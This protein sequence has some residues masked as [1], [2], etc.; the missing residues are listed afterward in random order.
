MLSSMKIK[1]RII[2]GFVVVLSL[3]L[4]ALLPGVMLSLSRLEHQATEKQLQ[5]TY[6]SMVE[7]IDTKGFMAQALSASMAANPQVQQAM[8][9]ED[10]QR[11]ADIVVPVFKAMKQTYDIRQFQFHTPDARSFL[12]AHK[13]EKFGDDL[14]SFRKTVVA[15]NREQRPVYGLERGVAGLGIRGLVPI[16]AG[17]RHLGSVEFGLSFGQPFFDHFKQTHPGV[18]VALHVA[19]DNR[20]ETFATTLKHPLLSP[21]DLQTAL[22]GKAVVRDGKLNNVPVALYAREVRDFSGNPIGVLEI[23]YDTSDDIKLLNDARNTVLIIGLIALA[24]ALLIAALI[25]RSIVRP[26]CLASLRMQDI[27]EGEGD[28]TQRLDVHGSDEVAEL[29]RNFNRF[30]ERVHQLVGQLAGATTQLAAASEELSATSVET[31]NHISRQQS[32]TDQV[33]SAMHEMTATAQTVA[34]NAADAAD[35][36]ASADSEAR[37]GRQVV[38]QTIDAIK[39]LVADVENATGVIHELESDSGDIGKV[40]DVIRGIAEQTNLLAL[41]A[42]IEAARAGEQGR[43]FAVVADEVRTLA[44]RT[45]QSTQEIHEMIE[46]LQ[47]GAA[48]AVKVMTDGQARARGTTEQA[49]QAGTSL[50]TITEAVA[51]INDMNA[52]IASAAEEQTAV[53][54]EINRNV[55]NIS[56]SVHHS[57]DGAGHTAQASDELAR[58]AAELQQRVNQFKI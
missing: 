34:Q 48:S 9:Q 16:Q 12:R 15:T 54:E 47:N 19:R 49:S 25:T 33:A 23:A 50:Q 28:L 21:E 46:R 55:V 56:Q 42:A 38:N 5:A 22:T 4:G 14:S 35:A 57:A 8:L 39:L 17:G 43:G 7:A 20:F 36:A 24:L 41:N 1:T 52:Q 32:E 10:R 6:A 26:V 40:L 44:Q 58:L 37:N 11:L 18:D 31:N 29:S 2:V 30:V 13:P 53:A 45:Q 51:R 27:A 3:T